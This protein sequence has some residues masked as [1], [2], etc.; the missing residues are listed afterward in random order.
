MTV[1]NLDGKVVVITGGANGIGLAMAR[2]FAAAGAKLAL[3]DI[4]ADELDTAVAEL[5]DDRGDPHGSGAGTA[6]PL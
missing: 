1:E 4:N 6:R 3:A 5:A 2:S